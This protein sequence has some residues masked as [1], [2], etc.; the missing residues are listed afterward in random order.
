MKISPKFEVASEPAQPDTKQVPHILLEIFFGRSRRYF[1]GSARYF[2]RGYTYLL[3]DKHFL[4]LF[5][6]SIFFVLYLKVA[7]AITTDSECWVWCAIC[8]GC[9]GADLLHHLCGVGR[10]P[11]YVLSF[12]S[13]EKTKKDSFYHNAWSRGTYR[14]ISP[15]QTGVTKPDVITLSAY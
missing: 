14:D 5:W 15:F 12:F 1:F 10:S 3:Y 2:F 9:S 4:Q 11:R 8:W 7:S 6:P 13:E